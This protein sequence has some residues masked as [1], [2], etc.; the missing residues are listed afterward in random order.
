MVIYFLNGTDGSLLVLYFVDTLLEDV[1][2]KKVK[3]INSN[4]SNAL[5]WVAIVGDFVL[6]AVYRISLVTNF[7]IS[8]FLKILLKL[9]NSI[10]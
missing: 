9:F 3:V 4:A 5:R 6:N 1:D 7:T 10:E 8:F 2:G